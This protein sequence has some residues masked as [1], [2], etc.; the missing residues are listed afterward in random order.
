MSRSG[1]GTR[2][3]RAHHSPEMLEE[4]S[5]EVD[6]EEA[7]DERDREREARPCTTFE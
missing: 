7:A 5:E 3:Y 6:S 2:P 1:S 4:D